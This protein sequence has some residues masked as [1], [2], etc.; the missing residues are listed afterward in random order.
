MGKSKDPPQFSLEKPYQQWK[1]E[2]KVWLYGQEAEK[3]KSALQVALS[4]PEKGCGNIR[5]RVFNSVKFFI[6]GATPNDDETVSPTAWKDLMTFLDKEFKKDD[7]AELFD[8]TQTFLHTHKSSSETVKDYINR[9]DDAMNQAAKAGMGEISQG[10]MMTMFLANAKLEDRDFKFVLS[11]IDYSKKDTLY[12][13]A[14]ESMIKFFG[15]LKSATEGECT[16]GAAG[17]IIDCTEAM[18]SGARGGSRGR[19]GYRGGSFRGR[20]GGRDQER[21][22]TSKYAGNVFGQSSQ[23]DGSQQKQF[24]R[25]NPK[26]NGNLRRCFNCQAVTHF[27]RDCPEANI[28]L[29]GEEQDIECLMQMQLEQQQLEDTDSDYV[30]DIAKTLNT[31]GQVTDTVYAECWAMTV[32]EPSEVLKVKLDTIKDMSGVGVMD[33]GCVSTAAG[34]AW[35]NEHIHKMPAK[36]RALIKVVP[37]SRIFRFGGGETAKSLGLYT[38]PV[39]IG[40]K[41]TFLNVDVV[42][43]PIPLLISKAAM[44]SAR[45]KIDTETDMLNVFGKEV[46]MVTV[47]A[48]H[49]GV[50]LSE[51]NHED[52]QVSEVM[53][54][55]EKGNDKSSLVPKIWEQDK[56]KKGKQIK[57]IHD[58][59]AHPNIKVFT[60]MI[61][62]S[63]GYDMETKEIIGRLYEECSTCL[64]F[65]KGK[66]KPK[67]CTPLSQEVNS[68]VALDLKLWPK[69]NTIILYITDL[70]SRYTQGV[71]IPDKKP[72]SVIRAFMDNWILGFFGSPKSCLVDNG[73]EFNNE[74]FKSMCE[75]LN[76]KLMTTGANSPWQNGIVERNHSIVDKMVLKM[77]ED[78][79]STPIRDLLRSALFT[80]NA[81]TNTSGYSSAQIVMGAN[82]R[83]PGIPYN[84]PPANENVTESEAVKQRLTT[85]F[86]TRKEYMKIEND[87]RLKKAL[88]SKIPPPRLEQYENGEEVFYRHGTDGVWHGP[89]AVIGQQ[90]KIIYIRQGRFILAASQTN[91]KKRYPG[92]EQREEKQEKAEQIRNKVQRSRQ[93]S[94]GS[95][96]DSDESESESEEEQR[97]SD[98]DNEADAVDADEAVNEAEVFPEPDSPDR[99]QTRQSGAASQPASPDSPQPVSDD[100]TDNINLDG[101]EIVPQETQLPD[102]EPESP[103]PFVFK[104]LPK[105][106]L[107][108]NNVIWARRKADRSNPDAWEKFTMSQ[109]THKRVKYGSTNHYGPHWNV[110]KEDGTAIGW[111]EDSWDWHLEGHERPDCVANY[112]EQDIE[113]G[114]KEKHQEDT[115]S[116]VVFIP[117]EEHHFPF[118]LEAKEKEINNFKNYKAYIEVPDRGQMRCSSSWV[119]TEKIYGDGEKG[120]KARLVVHGNQLDEPVPKDSPTVRKNTL[121]IMMALCVQ[122]GWRMYNCDVTAAFLQSEFMMRE[123]FVQP[124]KDVAKPGV[125]WKL[126]RPMYGLPEAGLC[127][128]LTI[129]KDLKDRGMKEVILDPAAYYWNVDGKLKGL[130]FGH[131]DDGYYCGD[132]DFHGI[133]I[134]PF[135]EKFKMGQ[136]MEGDF[137]SLGWNVTTNTDG[138]LKVSQRDYIAARVHKLDMEKPK[139]KYLHDKL[140][141]EQTKKLRSAIG[142][143]RWL[144]DQTRPDVAW[145]CLYLNTKQLE[146]TWREVKLFNAT[147]DKILR[148]PVDI[149]YR[150]LEPSKWYVTVFCDASHNTICDG[151]GSVAAYIIFLSNGYEKT[152]R[153]RCCILGWRSAKIKRVCKSSTDSETLALSEAMEEADLVRDQ[154]IQM[155]GIQKDLVQ[156]EGWCDSGNALDLI[157]Q[158]TATMGN[159]PL[160]NE[161]Q[162]IKEMKDDNRIKDLRW[163]SGSEQLADSLT[164]KN[165]GDTNL[166]ETLNKGWFFN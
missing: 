75:N 143:I 158:R 107:V 48:G 163:V 100:L 127:W 105:P 120:C 38:L 44:K 106:K 165:A 81:M 6:E 10:F 128:Y 90:N 80:K 112:V 25:L 126:E 84:D 69:F 104:E 141:E 91:I 34:R 31:T 4:F 33:T 18:W 59:L 55:E 140:D 131:V 98:S 35:T 13:Q 67:I 3:N 138:E 43:A 87:S 30:G 119:I 108:K 146:P 8:R 5:Q 123:V 22:V 152:K 113:F 51:F 26:Q 2:T 133:I 154:I 157:E 155:T 27:A 97:Q 62:T 78:N 12:P 32:V 15:S 41:N 135:F 99:V 150:K 49:Y 24:R 118:V 160:R 142:T 40:G 14:K 88:N 45:A 64:K 145:A 130:Y 116:Y 94:V 11:A 124:P 101:E 61:Q 166:I 103:E 95:R 17:G 159:I 65:G 60:K 96:R 79:P 125:L 42:D 147:V 70:F 115:G 136:V 66:I 149:I 36:T 7:I 82:P 50:T 162:L 134:K 83:I 54:N 129:N 23:N 110:I 132:D 139:D 86:E 28:N 63:G 58:Q 53:V 73:G 46:K 109:K 93:D 77:K 71:I 137:R 89:A 102:K 72:E 148:M 37:S 122:Y 85:M 39:N 111:Y 92:R 19:G 76:I 21:I 20:G 57:K 114:E 74:K 29:V 156:I 151:T 16:G 68:T 47:P 161:L 153:R 121:R 144:A 164:K 52:K 56:E 9:F 117:R 1:A